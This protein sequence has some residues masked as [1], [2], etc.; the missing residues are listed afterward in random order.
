MKLREATSDDCEL[1]FNWA[2]NQEVRANAINSEPIEWEGHR[3]WFESKLQSSSKLLILED[4]DPVGQIR[5][6]LEDGYYLI[7]Y[8]IQANQ[9]GKGYG[10]KIL[11]MTISNYNKHPFKALVKDTNKASKKAFERI[12]FVIAGTK[13]I[14]QDIYVVYEYW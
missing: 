11:E 2:N 6:D 7:D 10:K 4:N 3:D 14:K 9:R 1:L 13:Q 12:G 5:L 8:S